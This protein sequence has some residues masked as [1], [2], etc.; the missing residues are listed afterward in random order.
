[1]RRHA[2]LLSLNT[3]EHPNDKMSPLVMS[4]LLNL[5]VFSD[6]SIIK[7]RD[8]NI[9]KLYKVVKDKTLQ[10]GIT[11]NAFDLYMHSASMKITDMVNQSRYDLEKEAELNGLSQAEKHKTISE[12]MKL[13]SDIKLE[14]PS[15]ISLFNEEKNIQ[16]KRKYDTARE[17]FEYE[18]MKECKYRGTLWETRCLLMLLRVDFGVQLDTL[19]ME[20]L[21]LDGIYA[22]L[23]TLNKS[24]GS[25]YVNR[26][27]NQLSVKEIAFKLQHSTT[28]V[29]SNSS[30]TA[31]TK[32]FNLRPFVLKVANI[33]NTE[34]IED[35]ADVI[36]LLQDNDID[37]A[38]LKLKETYN[39][40]A[41]LLYNMNLT[42]VK[43]LVDNN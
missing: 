3:S 36:K 17:I 2:R 37:K 13:T 22:Y 32:V 24:R 18:T 15:L 5:F 7:E 29:Y 30:S 39:R 33:R 26:F 1:M 9:H 40:E 6:L 8:I 20:D 11:A 16:I 31:F 12:M 35:L 14:I 19:R 38:M 4:N 25:I 10:C 42:D 28:F 21:C 34:T 23:D 43:P 27:I 41:S